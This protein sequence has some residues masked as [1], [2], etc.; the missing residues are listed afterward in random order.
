MPLAELKSLLLYCALINY[1]AL[2]LWFA[3]FALG[4][5]GLYRL[6]G[7]WFRIAPARFDALHYQAMV[8]Y[9]VG[10]LL[11]NL[12]PLAALHLIAYIA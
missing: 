4:R 12:A 8:L 5:D 2:L 10:V 3:V 1:A 7:R 9:K 11:F 6:H